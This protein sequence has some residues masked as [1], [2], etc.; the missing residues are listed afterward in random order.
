[1]SGLQ[2]ND[3]CKQSTGLASWT[4][5]S[6]NY[7]RHSEHSNT[8]QRRVHWCLDLQ[9]RSRRCLGLLHL[10]IP[11]GGFQREVILQANVRFQ[12]RITPVPAGFDIHLAPHLAPGASRK[13][14]HRGLHPTGRSS[15]FVPRRP[16]KD[17]ARMSSHCSLRVS[18]RMGRVHGCCSFRPGQTF[19]CCLALRQLYGSLRRID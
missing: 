3:D 18:A 7:L 15:R 19:H 17:R 13:R 14:R 1:M 6:S 9:R 2:V 16:L 11:H 8:S 5:L 4:C 10:P 12:I